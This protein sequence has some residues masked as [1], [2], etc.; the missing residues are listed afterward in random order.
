MNIQEFLV[1][2]Y[3][4]LQHTT[5]FQL[6]NFNLF[7]GKNE[8][9]KTLTIDALVKL[10]LGKN[11]KHFEKID[12][13]AENPEGY[14]IIEDD[15]R[16][17]IKLTEKIDLTRIADLTPSECRNIF[18][19][20]NSDLSVSRDESEFYTNITD[21][22]IGLRTDEISSIKKA[23]QNL[24]KLTN[25]DSSASLSDRKE[26]GNIKSRIKNASELIG[27]IDDLKEE[28]KDESLDK[29][30]EEA[31]SK[32]EQI[33]DVKQEIDKLDDARKR[34][35]YEKG[36]KALDILDNSLKKVKDLEIYNESD[37]QLWRESEIDVEIQ[38]QEK[39]KL[40]SEL[41]ENKTEIKQIDEQLNE[42]E[43]EFEIFEKRKEKI[44]EEIQPRLE[45]YETK[46]GKL[47]NREGKSKFFAPMG[48]I[49]VILFGI[50]LL[51]IIFNPSMLFYILAAIFAISAIVSGIFWYQVIRDKAWLAEEFE[52]TKLTLS[53]LEL[54]ADNVEGILSNIQKF[55]EECSRRNQELVK[56]RGYRGV[57]EDRINKLKEERIPYIENKI[58]DA[59]DKID[60]VIKKSRE[61]SLK[62]YI[63]KLKQ[64]QNYERSISEQ[65]G[66]LD[67]IFGMTSKTLEENIEHWMSE[68]EKLEKYKNKAKGIK[69][70]ESIAAE[71]KQ[72]KEILE[73]ELGQING[74]MK[75]LQV[76]M[77]EIERKTNEIQIEGEQIEYEHLFCKTLV[78]LETIKDKLQS[79]IAK[80]EEQKDN[81]LEVMKNFEQI[82]AEE[83]EKVSELFGKDST[84]SK[85]FKAITNGLYKE[86][87]FNQETGSVEVK[88]EDDVLDAGK[89]SG[90]AYDQLYLSIR[91]ALGDKI[92]KG[93]K[94]FFIMD[95]PFIKADPDRIQRQIETLM[96]ISKSGWQI[97]YFSAKGEINEALQ[98]FIEQGAVNYIEVPSIYS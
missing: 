66:I 54:D 79:F 93:K 5:P 58:G 46:S 50:S 19:I 67:N 24:G 98:D 39:E 72:N 81:V 29:L 49:F 44:D 7:Y 45:A 16:K 90:G 83:K 23:L 20:R 35:K 71:A 82:E 80:N 86:V 22:L 53:K 95:D 48:I 74:K 27:K 68:T 78:D 2:R 33:N 57:L 40:I 61:E 89:L 52:R 62:G 36:K 77:E 56:I 47:A 1:T 51:G 13:V 87:V 32:T 76:K 4:P 43:R 63:Q 92:L 10:L 8:D 84:V 26:Y 6:T 75:S 17:K 12:R 14:V 55:K 97:L 21:R 15:K 31:V 65:R 30:E 25:P 85:Y 3:G 38:G 42:K 60:G 18:I 96:K 34:E 73:G 11:I 94:G 69:Y 91:L 70:N 64:K 28:I 37:E 41:G 9:G 88:L 59:K